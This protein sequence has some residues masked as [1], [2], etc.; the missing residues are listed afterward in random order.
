MD[1]HRCGAITRA[2]GRCLNGRAERCPYHSDE[3][4]ERGR[5]SA[6][7]CEQDVPR[8]PR[9]HAIGGRDLHAAG[10]LLLGDLLESEDLDPARRASAGA[11]LLRAIHGLGEPPESQ[12]RS[13]AEAALMGMVMHGLPPRDA[14]KWALAGEVFTPDALAMMRTWDPAGEPGFREAT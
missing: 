11:T 7:P 6:S 14:E 5:A 13:A 3:E 2:G 12:E 8:D 4:R 1:D 9:R 10:W